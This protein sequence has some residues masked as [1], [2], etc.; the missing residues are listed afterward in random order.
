MSRALGD[1]RLEAQE[2]VA[3]KNKALLQPTLAQ[4]IAEH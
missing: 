2:L 4:W 3:I 1:L